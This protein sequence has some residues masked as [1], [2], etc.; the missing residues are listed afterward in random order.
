M[1]PRLRN[2]TTASVTVSGSWSSIMLNLLRLGAASKKV[3]PRRR[4]YFDARQ[5]GVDAAEPLRG[6]CPVL[7]G[8]DDLVAGAGDVVPPHEY[9]L[10]GR[11]AA[12]EQR[13]GRPTRGE[14]ELIAADAEIGEVARLDDCVVVARRSGEHDEGVLVVG[15]QRHDRFAGAKVE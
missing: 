6:R 4:A 2:S 11:D 12:D 10:V 13:S 8:G 5:Y 7:V 15:A 1:Y 14:G 9:G 3:C